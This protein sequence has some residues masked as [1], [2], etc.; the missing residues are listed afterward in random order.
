MQ[1]LGSSRKKAKH[2]AKG[3]MYLFLTFLKDVWGEMKT[4]TL[5]HMTMFYMLVSLG[6]FLNIESRAS[7][8]IV[9]IKSTFSK[10]T[11]TC[12]LTYSLLADSNPCRKWIAKAK[13]VFDH[14]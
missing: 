13:H 6:I 8:L 10:T 7:Y 12:T 1:Y 14:I 3:I 9:L 2:W 11:H 5:T 4:F